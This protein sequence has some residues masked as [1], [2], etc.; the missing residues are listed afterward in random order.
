MENI[1]ARK[2]NASLEFMTAE[3]K[4]Q[5]LAIERQAA[6]LEDNTRALNIFVQAASRKATPT[7]APVIRGEKKG[8]A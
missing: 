8:G 5:T 7:E 6:A 3:I 4:K 1:E 2:I